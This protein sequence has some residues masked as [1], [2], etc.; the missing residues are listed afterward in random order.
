MKA[1]PG[2]LEGQMKKGRKRKSWFYTS[3]PQKK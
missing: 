1:K 2:Q 3:G